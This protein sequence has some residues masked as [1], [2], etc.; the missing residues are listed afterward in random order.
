MSGDEPG[1]LIVRQTTPLQTLHGAIS[2]QRHILFGG[3]GTPLRP[4]KVDDQLQGIEHP[5]ADKQTREDAP[6]GR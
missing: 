3:D 2:M 1:E 5:L 6:Y 4:P